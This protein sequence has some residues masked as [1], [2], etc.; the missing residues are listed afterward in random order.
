MYRLPAPTAPNNAAPAP[1]GHAP[2]ALQ[3]LN[4]PLS[5]GRATVL[6]APQVS[7]ITPG[8]AVVVV[9]AATAARVSVVVRGVVA[10]PAG[11]ALAAAVDAAREAAV[12]KRGLERELDAATA[13]IALARRKKA[14]VS[15]QGP[16][17][18][19]DLLCMRQRGPQS[20]CRRI[21]AMRTC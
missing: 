11:E 2:H 20:T 12:R 5:L 21:P 1:V 17:S 3:T 6:H 10:V 14:L 9:A 4:T 8:A 19:A 7:P 16:C 18:S 15:S 13:T